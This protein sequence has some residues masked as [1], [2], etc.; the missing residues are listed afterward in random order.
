M[1]LLVPTLRVGTRDGRHNAAERRKIRVSTQSVG[2]REGPSAKVQ[3]TVAALYHSRLS[4]R[5]RI[6]RISAR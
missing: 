3:P 6:L 4:R 5:S 1:K 2:T